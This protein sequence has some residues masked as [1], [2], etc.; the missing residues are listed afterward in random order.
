MLVRRRQE[1][2]EFKVKLGMLVHA[3]KSKHLGV[4]EVIPVSSKA[5]WSSS[6]FQAT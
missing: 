1:D 5:V 6:K 2:Q 3:F 4:R